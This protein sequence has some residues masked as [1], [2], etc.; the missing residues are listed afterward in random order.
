MLHRTF[1]LCKLSLAHKM[2]PVI[3][4]LVSMPLQYSPFICKIRL[5]FGKLY[6]RSL[7]QLTWY[8]QLACKHCYLFGMRALFRLCSFCSSPTS[9]CTTWKGLRTSQLTKEQQG[10]LHTGNKWKQKK[11]HFQ[12][13]ASSWLWCQP[14]CECLTLWWLFGLCSVGPRLDSTWSLCV[15]GAMLI[16]PIPTFVLW[17][18]CSHSHLPQ[19]RNKANNMALILTYKYLKYI[20]FPVLNAAGLF[21]FPLRFILASFYTEYNFT[22]FIVNLVALAIA[23]VP[24]FPV[25]HRFRPFR[26]NK[27]WLC[28]SDNAVLLNINCITLSALLMWFTCLFLLK[29][30]CVMCVMCVCVVLAPKPQHQTMHMRRTLQLVKAWGWTEAQCTVR[31]LIYTSMHAQIALWSGAAPWRF[32]M[33]C[34]LTTCIIIQHLHTSYIIYANKL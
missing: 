16:V 17:G 11:T 7:S 9:H 13:H 26:I 3:L 2:V 4:Y 20:T 14:S 6:V 33:K 21:P 1:Q 10:S 32:T 27:Y 29:S 8:S 12:L 18:S 22:H 28:C 30:A 24:K 5:H 31:R 19:V 15:V 34:N 25:F 23:V